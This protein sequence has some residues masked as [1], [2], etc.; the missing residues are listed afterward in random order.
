MER[1]RDAFEA[2]EEGLVRR[3]RIVV[4]SPVQSLSRPFSFGLFLRLSFDCFHALPFCIQPFWGQRKKQ[5]G[6]GELIWKRGEQNRN[7]TRKMPKGFKRLNYT[8]PS[9]PRHIN[10]K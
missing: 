9:N 7:G 8:I 10:I 5:G 6:F 1:V 3:R 2:C 4:V